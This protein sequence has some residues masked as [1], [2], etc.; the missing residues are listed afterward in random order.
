MSVTLVLC[1]NRLQDIYLYQQTKFVFI[2]FLT[3][4]TN[5]IIVGWFGFRHVNCDVTA[6]YRTRHEMAHFFI[7]KFGH[8]T[9][10]GPSRESIVELINIITLKKY[11]PM[12]RIKRKS[13]ILK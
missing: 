7:F 4:I 6:Q 8:Y 9:L 5:P 10:T 3:A 11:V 13:Y 12:Q 2:L 1:L